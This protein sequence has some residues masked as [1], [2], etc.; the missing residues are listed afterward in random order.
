[1]YS[2][3]GSQVKMHRRQYNKRCRY[4]KFAQV[5]RA[6]NYDASRLKIII[7]VEKA[8]GSWKVKGKIQRYALVAQPEIQTRSVSVQEIF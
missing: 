2:N 4:N 6:T 7:L 1:M 5:Y 8:E 3:N